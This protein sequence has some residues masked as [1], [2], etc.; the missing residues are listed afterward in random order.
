MNGVFYTVLSGI[1][2]F[3]E[4][5]LC[6]FHNCVELFIVCVCACTGTYIL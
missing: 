4:T 3:M 5:I 2:C 6:G 1:E